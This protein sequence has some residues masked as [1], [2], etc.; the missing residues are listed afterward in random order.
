MSSSLQNP[1]D[2]L[3]DLAPCR[4]KLAEAALTSCGQAIVDA[5]APVHD[6]VPRLK[7]A[8]VLKP[9][10]HGIDHTFAEGERLG[11][12]RANCLDKFVTIHLPTREQPQNEKLRHSIHESGA[13]VAFCHGASLIPR[14]NRYYIPF[15]ERYSK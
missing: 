1:L 6:L 15:D 8:I 11:A 12:L 5:A 10:E 3:S 4:G 14:A 13:V 7:G 9:V 2:G